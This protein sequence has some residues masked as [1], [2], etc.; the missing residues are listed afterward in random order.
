M[1]TDTSGFTPG[2]YLYPIRIPVSEKEI[3]KS[4]LSDR[5]NDVPTLWK[6]FIENNDEIK[7]NS[8]QNGFMM[9]ALSSQR[10]DIPESWKQLIDTMDRIKKD[11]GVEVTDLGD[12]TIQLK[13]NSG[14]MIVRQKYDWE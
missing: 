13:D 9:G 12:S 6:Q 4:I 14:F 10:N 1:G 7:I 8:Y 11:A 3:I 5:R 2:V